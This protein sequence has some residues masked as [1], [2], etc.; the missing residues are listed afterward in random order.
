MKSVLI[1]DDDPDI[2][3]L[4]SEALSIH[5]LYVVGKARDGKEAVEMY[6][7]L[8]PDIVLLDVSMPEYDGMYA[9]EKIN[10]CE[11]KPLAIMITGESN[12]YIIKRIT[13]LRPTAILEKPV[14]LK[15]LLGI[16][17]I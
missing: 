3:D 17:G 8:K 10:Q 1:V 12:P 6:D 7:A 16:I 15:N 11:R 13:Q 14:D 4:M 2:C 5:G 9:L